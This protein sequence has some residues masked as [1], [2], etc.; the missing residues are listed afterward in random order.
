MKISKIALAAAVTLVTAQAQ[1]G[2]VYLA[3][4]SATQANYRAALVSLCSGTAT[5]IISTATEVG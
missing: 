3:G 4:A 5:T 1:A 2:T